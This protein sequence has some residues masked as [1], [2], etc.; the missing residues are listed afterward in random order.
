MYLIYLNKRDIYQYFDKNIH[1]FVDKKI[2]SSL[3]DSVL[4]YLI[5]VFYISHPRLVETQ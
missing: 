5:L 2:D 3:W 4:F 1:T